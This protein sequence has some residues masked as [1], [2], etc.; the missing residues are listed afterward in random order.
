VDSKIRKA[1]DYYQQLDKKLVRDP[2]DEKL[3][4]LIDKRFK[5][6]QKYSKKPTI[7]K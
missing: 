3:Y 7:A 4:I 1:F 5:T 6:Y 2:I